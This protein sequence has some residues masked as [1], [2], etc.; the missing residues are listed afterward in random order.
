M[1]SLTATEAQLLLKIIAS[2][3]FTEG[4]AA[5]VAN[6]RVEDGPSPTF[7]RLVVGGPQDASVPDGPLPGNFPV[8]RDAELVGEVLVWVKNGV[9]SGLEF[10]WI[11]DVPPTQMPHPDDVVIS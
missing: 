8:Y 5:Q 1:R 2:S 7:L 3:V 11:S 10:A 4:L 6:V 9:L